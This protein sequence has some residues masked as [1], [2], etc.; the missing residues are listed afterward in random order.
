MISFFNSIG[1]IN[2]LLSDVKNIFG[3]TVYNNIVEVGG[4]SIISID[5]AKR[6]TMSNLLQKFTNE[7]ILYFLGI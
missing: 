6:I 5:E 1:F 2:D 4:S 7:G 3:D